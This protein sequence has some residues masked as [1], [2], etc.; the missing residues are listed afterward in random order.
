MSIA[1]KPSSLP[2]GVLQ[3]F[4]GE[5]PED[6][7]RMHKAHIDPVAYSSLAA[8]VLLMPFVPGDSGFQPSY[9]PTA[10]WVRDPKSDEHVYLVSGSILRRHNV[11][12]G[13]GT[14]CASAGVGL[15]YA[16][17]TPNGIFATA[18]VSPALWFYD[19]AADTWSRVATLVSSGSYA[20]VPV[21]DRQRNRLLLL[22]PTQVGTTGKNYTYD[23]ATRTLAQ[24]DSLTKGFTAS[25][26]AVLG[27]TLLTSCREGN[28]ASSMFS[29]NMATM[30]LMEHPRSNAPTAFVALDNKTALINYGIFIFLAQLEDDGSISEKPI[31]I[32]GFDAKYGRFL[33]TGSNDTGVL[34]GNNLF[35]YIAC[36]HSNVPALLC[37]EELGAE[38][39]QSS[40][41][42][43]RKL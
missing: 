6:W 42:Y 35:I 15:S 1:S 27:D 10:S 18:S 8:R 31:S 28:G 34:R 21:Y 3:L 30:E 20:L 12:T 4:A 37:L 36:S 38:V 7:E 17:A 2:S 40:V 39:P 23:I 43:A 11:L 33:T 25:C 5:V 26:M 14:V 41:F 24:I 13:Q 32:A 9:L 22:W 19:I 16:V 29:L